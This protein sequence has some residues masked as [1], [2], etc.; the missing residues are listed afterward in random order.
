MIAEEQ[1]N[2]L[3]GRAHQPK[4]LVQFFR[5]SPLSSV[6]LDLERDPDPGRDSEL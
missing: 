2:R 3:L 4:S 6:E 5:Q 1:Y